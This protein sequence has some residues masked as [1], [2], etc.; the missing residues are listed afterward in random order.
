MVDTNIA[1][2]DIMITDV[3]ALHVEDSLRIVDNTFD[4]YGF[5]HIPILDSQRKVV[6]M[7]SKEDLLRL[8]SIRK[9]FTDKEFGLIKVKDFMSTNLMMVSPDDSIGLAADV[10]MANKFHALPIV[11][12]DILVGLVTTHDLIKYAYAK[13][14]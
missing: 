10:F 14:I 12:N 13:V 1:L 3:I 5:H 4:K 6:G 2:K 8:I 11:E 7:I 9:E